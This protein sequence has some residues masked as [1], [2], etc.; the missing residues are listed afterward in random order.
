[1]TIKKNP[2]AGKDSQRFYVKKS[3]NNLYPLVDKELA[4]ARLLVYV[5][6]F[7]VSLELADV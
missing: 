5:V 1:M 3:V 4:E 6:C 2:R 7:F